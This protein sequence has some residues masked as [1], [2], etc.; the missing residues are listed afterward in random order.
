VKSFQSQTHYEV[1]E[2]SVGADVDEIRAAYARLTRLYSDEQVA[3][4]GLVDPLRAD[5]LRQRL[6]QALE[7]LTDEPRRD[8]YDVTIGLP[9]RDRPLPPPPPSRPPPSAR[10]AEVAG[11]WGQRF[12][13]VTSPPAAAPSAPGPTVFAVAVEDAAAARAL[14]PGA[15]PRPSQP[16]RPPTAAPSLA[17]P[18][19]PAMAA[20]S[21][22]MARPQVTDVGTHVEDAPRSAPAAAPAPPSTVSADAPG[23]AP[24]TVELSP[25]MAAPPVGRAEESLGPAP[26]APPRDELAMSAPPDEPISAGA[27][28][29]EAM[30]AATSQGASGPVGDEGPAQLAAPASAPTPVPSVVTEEAGSPREVAASEGQA[31]E[32]P[33]A[34]EAWQDELL[35]RLSDDAEV[36]IIAARATPREY[37]AEPRPRPYEVPPGVEFNGD[38]LRQVRMARGLSLLQLSERT[39]ISVKHLE[40]VEG[41]RYEAL[42][43]PVYLRGI[44]MNLAR[45]LGLDGLRVS[46][47][48]LTFVEARRAKG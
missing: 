32:V 21:A 12:A 6:K 17:D 46:R 25:V 44:L 27:P 48:Y 11:A 35:P 40:N 3:L 26:G 14:V 19:V 23:A 41:D 20:A 24:P 1:L 10:G 30:A 45:E 2:I 18:Q 5:L 4:Y 28:P 7:V 38:L 22:A 42:P 33:V 39:R 47:S 36:S 16:S 9:P 29:V 13:W 31:V 34:G 43:A 15:P 8:A 37:R